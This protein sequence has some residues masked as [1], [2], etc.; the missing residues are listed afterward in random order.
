VAYHATVLATPSGDDA[1]RWLENK[2]KGYLVGLTAAG[3]AS[4]VT[5]QLKTRVD[6]ERPNATDSDSFPSGHTSVSA[7]FA[8]LTSR[9]LRSIALEDRTRRALDIGLDVLT[10]G[11]AWSRVEAGEHFPSDTL[12][13]IALGNFVASFVNDA[14]L[15]AT[16]DSSAKFAI[17]TTGDGPALRWHVPF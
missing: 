1:G 6:R 5:E 3:A 9:N 4:L 10:V 15:G 7:A 12:V 11:T 2:A 8:R 16:D 14:F 13:S 17:A